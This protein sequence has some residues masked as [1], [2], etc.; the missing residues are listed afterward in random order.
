MA[1]KP[2]I[3]YAVMKWGNFREALAPPRLVPSNELIFRFTYGG[4]DHDSLLPD[5]RVRRNASLGAGEATIVLDNSSAAW[6]GF[7]A[8][9]NALG[10]EGIVTMLLDD[11]LSTNTIKL[12]TGT[13]MQVDYDENR[14]IIKL[15]DKIYQAL[16]V[17]IGSGQV[18]A[19]VDGYSAGHLVWH[20]LTN[21]P[22]DPF[23]G[24]G[25]DDTENSSNVD[26]DFTQHWNWR[27]MLNGQGYELGAQLTGHTARWC[28]DRIAKMTNSYIWQ[29]GDG[30]ITFAPPRKNGG[31]YG[32]STTDNIGLSMVTDTIVNDITVYH[33]YDTDDGAWE[34][35]SGT[36]GTPGT[37]AGDSWTQYGRMSETDD[38]NAIFHNT[39]DSAENQ[40]SEQIGIYASP[41]RMFGIRAMLPAFEDDISYFI[42]V[43]KAVYGVTGQTGIVEDITY[44][45]ANAQVDIRA[46]W[47][48]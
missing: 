2:L 15:R 19:I 21:E 31:V 40:L 22:T 7:H 20:I 39:A 1:N 17:R 4:S 23:P 3:D 48:W 45:L 18:P 35:Q 5:S 8:D 6:N 34:G 36:I 37:I 27:N 38:N 41:I 25:L 42:N 14:V 28:L 32:V 33:N 47:A 29:Q 30:R 46:R 24:M 10:D 44:D 12:F 43:T 16:R 13:V 26:I 9:R 11:G